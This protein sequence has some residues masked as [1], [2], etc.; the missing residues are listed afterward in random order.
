L[1]AEVKNGTNT[2]Q[3]NKKEV[4][5]STRL[6]SAFLRMGI[7]TIAYFFFLSLP[8]LMILCPSFTRYIRLGYAFRINNQ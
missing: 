5:C 3:Q 1:H 2:D 7:V 4:T 6:D 8:V